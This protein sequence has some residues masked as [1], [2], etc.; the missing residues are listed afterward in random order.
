[1]SLELVPIEG[2]RILTEEEQQW[3]KFR[4]RDIPPEA[5]RRFSPEQQKEI[6]IFLVKL[7]VLSEQC[8]HVMQQLD[9]TSEEYRQAL[10]DQ[11]EQFNARRIKLFAALPQFQKVF[12]DLLALCASEPWKELEEF[13]NNLRHDDMDHYRETKLSTGIAAALDNPFLLQMEDE[14]DDQH[15]EMQMKCRTTPQEIESLILHHPLEAL[16]KHLINARRVSSGEFWD[17]GFY[18]L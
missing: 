12:N 7:I 14:I 9:K 2:E 5:F 11:L 18:D 3:Q 6:K 16:V 1:M 15:M 10:E 8:H 4:A 17:Q 13:L